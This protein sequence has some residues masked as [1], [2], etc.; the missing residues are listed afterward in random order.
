MMGAPLVGTRI[1]DAKSSLDF[2]CLIWS[3]PGKTRNEKFVLFSVFMLRLQWRIFTTHFLRRSDKH[4]ICVCKMH[5]TFSASRVYTD[6]FSEWKIW[7]VS[8]SARTS[9]RGKC[10]TKCPFTLANSLRSRKCAIKTCE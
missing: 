1:L 6:A 7:H 10:V 2:I 5:R 4:F 9:R 3:A 8:V